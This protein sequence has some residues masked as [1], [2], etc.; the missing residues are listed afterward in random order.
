MEPVLKSESVHASIDEL[1]LSGRAGT[2]FQAEELFLDT[3]LAD[4]ARL[5]L[6][7]DDREF[8][9]HEAVKLLMAH[10]SRR[11]EDAIP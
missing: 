4:I 9:R 5:V 8:R 11:L 10:G 1:L 2:A 6:T 7:L 3:H